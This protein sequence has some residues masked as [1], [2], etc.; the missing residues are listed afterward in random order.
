MLLAGIPSTE[1]NDNARELIAETGVGGVWLTVRNYASLTQTRQLI[2]DLQALAEV[3]LFVALDHEGGDVQSLRDGVAWFPN[4]M[5]LGATNDVVLAHAAGVAQASELRAIGFN[6]NFAPVLDV[7]TNPRNPIINVRS[8]GDDAERVAQLGAA[9]AAGLQAGGVLA[10]G[11]HFPGHG[12][13]AIDSHAALPTVR[14]MATLPFTRTMPGGI[15]V[16]HLLVPQ[17]DPDLPASLS[18]KVISD[19]LR[20][21]LGY[22]GLVFSDD[23]AR[24]QAVRDTYTIGSAAVLAVQAGADVLV[25]NGFNGAAVEAQNALLN[26]VQN[27]TLTEAR[28]DESVRRILRV[29]LTPHIPLPPTESPATLAATIAQSA[30]TLLP[31]DS[32]LVPLSKDA[33]VVLIAP[34]D[35][36]ENSDA[37]TQLGV[38]LKQ[39]GYTVREFN[40][41]ASLANQ[42]FTLRDSIL[43]TLT[44]NTVILMLTWDADLGMKSSYGWQQETVAALTARSDN[45]IVV[46]LHTPYDPRSLPNVDAFLFTY[47]NQPNQITALANV[48]TGNF[49]P[50]GLLPVALP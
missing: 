20:G 12:D 11:K 42:V 7:N 5:A 2:A 22:D 13:V 10:V 41:V 25:M 19:Y 28:I 49:K 8:L 40:Y 1:V 32:A 50:Q 21:S 31:T 35:T 26:A 14:E 48:L 17:L 15:M 23:I 46:A 30:I 16:G 29:K 34:S 4:P 39:A 38:Q 9:Y 18:S 47:G 45:V 33:P 24:M 36:L 27:G 6:V 37:H 3:P 44:R 43:S